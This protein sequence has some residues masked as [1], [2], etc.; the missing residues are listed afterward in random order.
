M[1][2]DENLVAIEPFAILAQGQN[3]ERSG[4]NYF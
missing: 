4:A 2:A 1:E 3:V